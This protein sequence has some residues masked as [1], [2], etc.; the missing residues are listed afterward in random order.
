VALLQL[1]ADELGR[2]LVDEVDCE[3]TYAI[4]AERRRELAQALL[5]PTRTSERPGSR[6]SRRAAASPIPLE[7]PVTSATRG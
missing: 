3:R 1:R 7:A 2:L 6:A 4:L 5:A